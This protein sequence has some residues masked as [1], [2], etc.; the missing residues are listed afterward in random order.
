MNTMKTQF[1]TQEEKRIGQKYYYRFQMLN[2]AGFN[3]LGDTI[4]Y[5]LAIHF[6]AGNLQLGYIASAPFITGF[7]LPIIPRLLA[8]KDI[9]KVQA[10]SW[11]FRGLTGLGYSLLFLLSGQRAV[12]LIL[13]LYSLFCMF[14]L[15]GVVV[16]NPMMKQIS[17]A[18]TRSRVISQVNI[19]FQSVAIA[20]KLFSAAVTT[21]QRFSGVLGLILLEFLGFVFNT[22]SVFQLRKVPSRAVI[23]YR[24][25]RTLFS[26]LRDALRQRDQRLILLLGWLN[27]SIMVL[28]GLITPF[29]R[30]EM[31]FRTNLVVLFSA[32]AGLA[33]VCAGLY[34]RSFGDRLGSRVF[35][36]L[37]SAL[38][39]LIFI[40]WMFIPEGTPP[41]LVI[42]L[43]F[44]GI[45]LISANRMFTNRM[46]LQQ[47]PEEEGI[48]YNSMNNFMAA[49]ATSMFGFIG[50]MSIDALQGGRLQLL[51]ESS[52]FNAYALL[53]AITAACCAVNF[54]LALLL[55]EDV[56]ISGKETAAMLL[57]IDGIRA[58]SA[59]GRLNRITDPLK[60]KTVL[61]SIGSNANRAAT[62]EIRRS[63]NEPFSNDKRDMIISL[64]EHPRKMLHEE[65][66]RIASDEDSYQQ[67][68]AVFALG[69]YPGE[70][71]EEVLLSVFKNADSPLLRSTTAKSLARIGS[72]VYR[73]QIEESFRSRN[74]ILIQMNY[75]IAMKNLDPRKMF[76]EGL[77][78]AMEQGRS[79]AYRQT[80]YALFA[81]MM[82]YEPSLSEIYQEQNMETGSGLA[83]FF[84]DARDVRKILDDYDELRTWFADRELAPI[85]LWCV[86]E[87]GQIELQGLGAAISDAI[88]KAA[89]QPERFIYDD[90]LAC[91][92]FTY[93]L[94]REH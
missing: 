30:I 23:D 38:L 91:F 70:R 52:P 27:T 77:F 22:L 8:G 51:L 26:V 6:G 45:F 17:S 56:G 61:Y 86:G 19:S 49:I 16:I 63:L 39:V 89:E 10:V 72:S 42:L 67:R 82:Q 13:L 84:E 24:P 68:E 93:Q 64:F 34:T 1:L 69:A 9:L 88:L 35:I 11:F 62:E 25:G 55:H 83:D 44:S 31:H 43:G 32:A 48:V 73:R 81:D 41:I 47:I 46:F 71:T 28:N 87:L 65:L 15:V 76:R 58:Y 4:V 59:I 74:P 53:F 29:L 94:L 80:M 3:F 5:L 66:C 37:D 57:S 90:A 2:G 33:V 54:L 92:Y 78:L 20:A 40:L 60:K 18:R 50:G 36:L 79:A 75:A 14:R 7:F 12:W 85:I 21:L